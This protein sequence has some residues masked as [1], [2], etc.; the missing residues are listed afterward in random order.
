MDPDGRGGGEELRGGEEEDIVIRIDYVRKKSIF[1]KSKGTHLATC[2][3]IYEAVL[4]LGLVFLKLRLW[5]AFFH[6]LPES[7]R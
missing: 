1:N 5:S 4:K 2:W 6:P 7:P 3:I